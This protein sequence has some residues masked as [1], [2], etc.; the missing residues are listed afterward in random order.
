MIKLHKLKGIYFP[1]RIIKHQCEFLVRE[2]KA[3]QCDMKKL[4]DHLNWHKIVNYYINLRMPYEILKQNDQTAK[5]AKIINPKLCTFSYHKKSTP[6]KQFHNLK[7]PFANPTSARKFAR[8]K[9]LIGKLLA[10]S[11]ISSSSL[12][13]VRMLFLFSPGSNSLGTFS[14]TPAHSQLVAEGIETHTIA[15]T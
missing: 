4:P 7:A 15:H 6:T 9:L 1:R 3:V 5:R 12:L 14:P 8:I 13:C 11:P 2:V 10:S